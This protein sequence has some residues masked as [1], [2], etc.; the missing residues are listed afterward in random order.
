MTTISLCRELS[1]QF[2]VVGYYGGVARVITIYSITQSGQSTDTS[3]ILLRS[4][5]T[6]SEF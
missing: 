4:F 3:I 5:P 2:K 1:L 6:K